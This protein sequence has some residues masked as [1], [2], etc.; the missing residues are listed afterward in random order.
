MTEKL[1]GSRVKCNEQR[2]GIKDKEDFL[3]YSFLTQV[4]SNS[5][6]RHH[7]QSSIL[8][9]PTVT[10]I[11]TVCQKTVLL[12]KTIILKEYSDLPKN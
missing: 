3:I 9:P 7:C 2:K 8:F 11:H 10:R 4:L 1:C 5:N 6:S 12:Q